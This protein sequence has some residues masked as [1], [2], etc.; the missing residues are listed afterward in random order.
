MII[1]TGSGSRNAVGL[2]AARKRTLA[3]LGEELIDAFFV[4]YIHE[5]D[6]PAAIFGA[7]GVFDELQRWKSEGWIRFVGAT[8]HNRNLAKQLAADPR[9]DLLM[10]RFN[11]AHRKAVREVFPTAIRTR[12]PIV[13]FTATRWGTLLESRADWLVHPERRI[14]RYCPLIRRCLVVTAPRSIASWIRPETLAC[15]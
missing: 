3:V 7:G 13:A 1:A 8:T 10:H 4:E 11:M 9:V 5:A 6:D 2:R 15:G 14:Y 12:T